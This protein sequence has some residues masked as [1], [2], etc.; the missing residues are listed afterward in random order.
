MPILLR[1]DT[2]VITD[3]VELKVVIRRNL[4]VQIYGDSSKITSLRLSE[5]LYIPSYY[6]NIV[7]SALL[8][9][10]G[11]QLYKKT[12]KQH[13]PNNVVITILTRKHD[14]PLFRVNYAYRCQD[15]TVLAKQPQD[16]KGKLPLIR[17]LLPLSKGQVT[18]R[19]PS[20]LRLVGSYFTRESSQRNRP[21]TY[22]DIFKSYNIYRISTLLQ[23]EIIRTRDV[24]FNKDKQY[25][26]IRDTDIGYALG[27]N[28]GLVV[29]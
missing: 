6:T 8:R 22:L 25:Q 28:L 27:G 7:S 20:Q 13:D 16:N 21:T 18:T 4:V 29:Q 23:K 24:I 10:K 12:D 14:L 15:Y 19:R 11:Y 5:V 17:K 26:G 2:K 9:K 3:N 1:I